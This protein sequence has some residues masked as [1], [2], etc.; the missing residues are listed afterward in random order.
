M[1]HFA[2]IDQSGTVVDIVKV[3]DEILL[4][5]NGDENEKLGIKFL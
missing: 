2:K 4:D 5:E 3:D 1:A